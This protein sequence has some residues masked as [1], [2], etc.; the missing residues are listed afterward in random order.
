MSHEIRTP[1]NGIM[2]MTELLAGNRAHR[3]SSASFSDHGADRRP[4]ACSTIINDILDFSKIEA[5][6]LEVLR[7]PFAFRDCLEGTLKTLAIRAHS[8]RAGTGL[9][10]CA[11]RAEEVSATRAGCVKFW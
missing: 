5:G 8:R 11:G 9:R 6:K 10:D 7:D 4:T 1:M 2:G 3:R